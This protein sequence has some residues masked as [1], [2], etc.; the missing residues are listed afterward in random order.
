MSATWGPEA[1]ALQIPRLLGLQSELKGAI[2]GNLAR[3]NLKIKL[4]KRES[5]QTR[6]V[7][8]W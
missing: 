2:L 7:A 8:Y 6:N 1:E 4:K 3:T 5:G